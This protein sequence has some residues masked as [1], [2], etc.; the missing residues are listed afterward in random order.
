MLESRAGPDREVAVQRKRTLVSRVAGAIA[1]LGEARGRAVL[2]HA[3]TDPA[4]GDRLDGLHEEVKAAL[5]GL[6]ED[7]ELVQLL[8]DITRERRRLGVHDAQQRERAELAI[9]VAVGRLHG[10]ESSRAMS[11]QAPAEL[12]EACGF[13]RVM[14][15]SA[16][17]SRWMPDTMRPT[18]HGDPNAAE[19]ARFAQSDNEI[20]LA[21]L[22]PETHMVRHRVPVI[23]SDSSPH[24]YKPLV[25]V[26]RTTSYVA[27][28]IVTTQ[29]VIGFFHADR[30]GQR[31]NVT[32][33][34]RD[35]IAL[36]AA[37]FAVLF[38]RAVL[39]E[40]V[41]Q[42]RALWTADLSAIAAGFDELTLRLSPA[43]ALHPGDE[44]DPSRHDAEAGRRGRK[45]TE[46]ERQ[47]M[48][49]VAGG[50]TNQ[51]IAQEL[52]LSVDTVK[53]H[54]KNI[55]GKL[56]ATSRAG[57]VAGYLRPLSRNSGAT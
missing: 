1:E 40:R 49:L 4:S 41:E 29:R 22:L 42:Q 32:P 39:A 15:S 36:F 5:G 17:G 12:R 10:L 33:G 21:N 27:A 26:T 2:D 25:K 53:T 46:R 20:P 50:A 9:G 30:I 37:E 35:N 48:R 51:A 6:P 7:L 14:I 57:A 52:V 19:F 16:R 45:L 11:R 18:D 47:V 54:V 31:G 28:P 23:V 24:A 55:M 56:H 3:F 8:V 13:T 43:A 38:E 44:F 34:D